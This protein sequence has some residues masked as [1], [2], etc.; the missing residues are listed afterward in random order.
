[1]YIKNKSLYAYAIIIILIIIVSFLPEFL[2]GYSPYVLN[3]CGASSPGKN[4]L[5]GTDFLGRDI[6]SRTLIG[7]RI[8]ILTGVVARACSVIL[9]LAAGLAIGLSGRVLRSILN[10]IV[11]I[12][13]SIPSLLL[14][15]ALA[16]SMG[17]GYRTI[18]I[19][20]TAGTWAAVA[21]FVSVQVADIKSRDYIQAADVI[22]AGRLRIV[23]RCI[24]PDL[25]PLLIPV[26]TTG[27]A[28]S[29]MMEST[30]SFL[31]LSG[32]GVESL[33]SWG[34]M[35]QEGSKFIFDA[36]WIIIP[37]SVFLSLLILCFNNTGDKIA[38]KITFMNK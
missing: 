21:R 20:I 10:G 30:L 16:V 19:A 24:I 3:P 5:F 23:V 36:P 22:G 33:P 27:I 38:E 6:L 29:I 14:V 7:G 17:E 15:M 28:S 8:S 25:M 12:F 9:G 37:P 1:M 2:S 26:I 31:G 18:I 13:L 32:R 11:D 34:M 4:H 35:I